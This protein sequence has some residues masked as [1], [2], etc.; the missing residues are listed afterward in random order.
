MLRGMQVQTDEVPRFGFEVR[1]FAGH[2]PVQPIG[3]SRA[4]VRIRWTVDLVRPNSLA[5]FRQDRWVLPS[6]RF[7][8]RITRG[9]CILGVAT[10]GLLSGRRPAKPATQS[11]S[12]RVFQRTMAGPL[13]FR[14]LAIS[15]SL[16]PSAKARIS[17]CAK[18][19]AVCSTGQ[20][21]WTSTRTNRRGHWTM[22]TI[23]WPANEQSGYLL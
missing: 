18:H 19:I 21:L 9:A 11:C 14:L 15:R 2:I 13:V 17:R 4:R 12:N 5:S 6:P 20:P 23:P 3:F 16:T 7:T 8:R 1:I 22:Y 10:R